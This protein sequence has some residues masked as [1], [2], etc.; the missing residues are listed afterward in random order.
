MTDSGKTQSKRGRPLS[1]DK[2]SALQKAMLLFWR[3]GYEA[4]AISDLTH[5]MGITAPSLYSAF[6]DKEQLFMA[7]IARYI[8]KNGCQSN[9]IFSSAPS[10]KIALEL[11]LHEQAIKLTQATTPHGC[12]LV[13]AATNCSEQSTHVQQALVSRREATRQAIYAR[14]AQGIE[15]GDVRS[16]SPIATLADYFA[17]VIQ[18]MT[19]QARDG[20]SQQQL[21]DVGKMAMQVWVD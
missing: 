21:Q 18:G 12:M 20:A 13:T 15:D 7:C 19:I 6:G 17:T 1:F 10:A 4:T 5:A 2:D 16:E 9:P 3:Y 11:F 8:E 14:L